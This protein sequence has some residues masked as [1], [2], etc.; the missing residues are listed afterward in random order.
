[1]S[2]LAL[3]TGAT[4]F[5]GSHMVEVLAK[6]G[7]PDAAPDSDYNK[8]CVRLR[9]AAKSIV[10]AVKTKNYDQAASAGSAIGKACAECHESYRS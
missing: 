2:K 3:V 10:E 1:M 7:M 8:F 9:D 6:E 5:I 4:G